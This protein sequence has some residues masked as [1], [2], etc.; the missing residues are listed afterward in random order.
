MDI[1]DNLH[2]DDLRQD[3]LHQKVLSLLLDEAGVV[4]PDTELAALKQ[5]TAIRSLLND[6]LTKVSAKADAFAMQA[7]SVPIDHINLADRIALADSEA[8]TCPPERVIAVAADIIAT[9]IIA[10]EIKNSQFVGETREQPTTAT[11][12]RQ[13]SASLSQEKTHEAI[14]SEENIVKEPNQQNE[15][16]LLAETLSAKTLSAKTLEPNPPAD[17]LPPVDVLSPIEIH[18]KVPVEEESWQAMLFSPFEQHANA[19]SPAAG[20]KPLRPGQIPVGMPNPA[21]CPPQYT[22][23]K[24]KINIANARVGTPF[25][26]DVDISLD[27]G[28]KAEILD[29]SFAKDIGLIFDQATSSLSGTPTESGDIEVTVTWSCHSAPYFSTKVLFIVNPDPRSLWKILEPPADDRYFKE[30]VDHKLIS[31]PGINIAAASRRGRSHEHVGS[32]RDDDFFI[33]SNRDTGWNIMLVAD[34]A[35]SAKNSRK[36]SQIVTETVGHYLSAQLSGD[37]GRELKERIINWAPED[38]RVVGETF[39][40]Q[41]HHASVIAINNIK[42]ESLIAEETVKSYSTTLLA[43]V[44]FRTGTE[45]FAAAFWM[46]DGAIA[47]YGPVG[48]VRILGTPDSGEYAGQ[49]RFLDVDAVGDPEF[50][51]R[52]SI[53]KWT[54]ISHLVLMTDGV[55]DPRF[56]TDNGLQNP[57]KWDALIAEISPC[58]SDNP[59]AAEQLAEWLNFFSPGNHDDRTIVVSW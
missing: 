18:H 26:S 43:T 29:V 11:D 45:L 14:G 48:K 37:K 49:T 38:Q 46:G 1:N 13:Q 41:F 22:Q 21:N 40:R 53:G 34:G 20:T 25:H 8:V 42:N 36:G 47:A 9:D 54:G 33:S 17:V 16:L 4:L 51:K 24:A 58:L 39:I 50:S 56:E 12:D 7:I 35:G 59:Q 2:Q 23:P 52:V 31:A 6:L 15:R 55:S 10:T 19:A 28:A 5:D 32:F 27:N 57:Q 3:D 30:N 44:S